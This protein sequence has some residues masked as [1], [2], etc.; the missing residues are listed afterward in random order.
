VADGL[1]VEHAK[2]LIRRGSERGVVDGAEHLLA[3]SNR[4]VPIETGELQKSG[5]VSHDGLVAAVSYHTDHA[6]IE[7]EDMTE[8]HDSG[9][10]AKFLESSMYEERAAILELIADDIRKE[11]GL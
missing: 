11:A 10:H 5:R 6:V 2:A 1:E 8:R 7:H 9:R 4:K 3:A